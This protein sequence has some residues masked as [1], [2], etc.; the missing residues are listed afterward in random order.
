MGDSIMEA[1]EKGAT[2]KLVADAEKRMAAAKKTVAPQAGK[3]VEKPAG[4]AGKQPALPLGTVTLLEE[5]TNPKEEKAP[6]LSLDAFTKQP[7]KPQ[8]TAG[9]HDSI[10]EAWEKGATK[11][12]VADAEKRMAAAKKTAAPQAGKAV[13]KPAGKAGK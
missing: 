13:V 1:W 11:K 9:K 12:L 2:K 10:M 4:K 3:T 8:H 5:S 6:A 7:A